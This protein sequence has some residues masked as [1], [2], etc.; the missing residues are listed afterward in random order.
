[1][2][3][4]IFISDTSI[5]EILNEMRTELRKSRLCNGKLNYTKEYVYKDNEKAVIWFTPAAYAKMLSA[6]MSFESEIAWHGVVDRV[7]EKDNEFLIS[8]IIVYPQLATGVTVEMDEE[9]YMEMRMQ[10]MNNENYKK[11]YMQGHSHVNMGTSPSS[12]DITHQEQ[13]LNQTPED[14]FYIFMIW[15]KK[16]Q[17]TTVIYDLRENTYY[18]SSEIEYRIVGEDFKG[19]LEEA[20]TNIRNKYTAG[21]NTVTYKAP[22]TPYSEPQ[23]ASKKKEDTKPSTPSVPSTKPAIGNGWKGKGLSRMDENGFDVYCYE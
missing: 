19:F 16:L 12:V 7:P 6:I 5:E 3:K 8:D 4:P 18:E 9:K 1:M 21:S 13:I 22:T 11:L 23:S 15:N 17:Q 14:K 20:K 2:A 10:N